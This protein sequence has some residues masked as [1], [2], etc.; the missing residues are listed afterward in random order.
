MSPSEVPGR[1]SLGQGL[2]RA[3]GS[4]RRLAASGVGRAVAAGALVVAVVA[5]LAASA[6]GG[7]DGPPLDPRSTGASGT[8]AV[9]DVARRLGA[10]VRLVAPQRLDGVLADR[11]GA[12]AVVLLLS[13]H[14]GED[15]RG[16]L[17]SWVGDGG[18]V[19]VADPS[20][21]LAPEVTG[22]SAVGPLEVSLER[23]DCPIP[24]LADVE[25][26]HAPQS[27]LYEVAAGDRACFRRRRGQGAWLVVR[28][29]GRGAVVALGGPTALVNAQLGRGDNG[30]LAATL[31]TSQGTEPASQMAQSA[32]AT[33]ST[34]VVVVLPGRPGEGDSGLWELVPDGVRLAAAQLALA[35]LLAA[36]WR[37]RRLGDPVHEPQPVAVP[38]SQ[39]VAAVGRLY[40]GASARARAAQALRAELRRILAQ[41]LGLPPSAPPDAVVDALHR[42]A[43]TGESPVD[44]GPSS[45]LAALLAGTDPV[46]DDALV[47]LGQEVERVRA[48]MAAPALSSTVSAPDRGTQ[49]GPH[50]GPESAVPAGAARPPTSEHP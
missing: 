27:V 10:D 16:A 12:G 8:K 2:A 28:P 40:H 44:A 39:L 5:L 45:R 21:P 50:P 15:S 33:G 23:G 7:R 20:S 29:E 36:W 31:L 1:D 30:L 4:H 17:V 13:D 14:L 6:P 3:R 9:L 49:P 32:P 47:G 38:A 24:V 34:T 19:V 22:T 25:R 48:R 18:T 35:F 42:S 43:A 37:G 26:V 41:R 11:P 46:D